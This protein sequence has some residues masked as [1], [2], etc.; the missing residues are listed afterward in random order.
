ME[1]YGMR[2]YRPGDDLRRV[3]WRAFGRTGRLLV[4][5]AEQGITDRITLILDTSRTSH[6]PGEVSDSFEAGVKLAAS[7]GVRH[8]REGYSVTLEGNGVRLAGPLRGRPSQIAFLDTLARVERTDNGLDEPIARLVG[9]ARRDAHIV[10]ITPLLEADSASRLKLL[11]ERGASVLVCALVWSEESTTTLG[12]AASLGC[13]VIE[14][15]PNAPL[16][17]AFRHEVGAGRL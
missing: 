2:D 5:E 11:L 12:T 13:Q 3:V 1:F 16:A 9:D 14:L 17:A 10:L 15:R 7:L 4:R 8:L 6:T